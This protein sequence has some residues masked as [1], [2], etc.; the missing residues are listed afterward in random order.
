MKKST[1]VIISVFSIIVVMVVLA[2]AYGM[3]LLS[4]VSKDTISKNNADLG[5]SDEIQKKID[6]VPK[7]EE[8]VN[9]ALFGVDAPENQA[10]RS[11]AIMILTIDNA[12]DKLK[13]TSIMRDSYVNID[14]HGM[15]KINHAYAFG[16]PQLAIK[17]LNSNFDLNIKDYAMVNFS[18]LPKVIDAMGGVKINVKDYEVN[19]INK[20]SGK[21]TKISSPGTYTL[22]GEQ[23]LAYSRIRYKGN[24]DYERTERQRAVL[25]A[26]F[27]QL[28]KQG[29]SKYVS[30]TKTLLPMIKTSLSNGDIIKTGTSILSSGMKNLEQERFP[31]DEF[32]KGKKINGIYY[33]TFNSTATKEQIHKYIFEDVKAK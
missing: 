26:L 6:D 28:Q 16:G 2:G 24:G 13:L 15:D 27:T 19:E 4:K 5:I 21:S 9:I 29:V 3:S 33:L 7:S 14:G 31:L 12:H 10:G 32:S 25:S 30:L 17:T 1:K 8:I 23:A 20:G 18:T 22:T 11:D